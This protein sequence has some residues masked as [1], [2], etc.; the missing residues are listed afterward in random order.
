M[1]M[2]MEI[3]PLSCQCLCLCLRRCVVRVNRD[4]DSIR[5]STRRLCLRRTGLNVVSC[6]YAGAYAYACVRTCKLAFTVV[7]RSMFVSLIRF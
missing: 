4:D 3:V 7:S 2:K 1:E 5:I 6:A